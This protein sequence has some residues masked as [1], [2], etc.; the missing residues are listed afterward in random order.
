MWMM[1][2]QDKPEDFVIATGITTPVRDFIVMS[3]REVGIEIEWSGSGEDEVAKVKACTNPEYN[4]PVGQEVVCIDKRYYRPAE[5]D[6]LIG[7]PTKAKTKLGWKPKYDLP[8]L[9]K[10]MVAADVETFKRDKYLKDG[11]HS[12]MNYHE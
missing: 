3:F 9:V 4:V 5:V 10:E 2:Q 1:L 8:M 6:L 7:D 11:G 12:V